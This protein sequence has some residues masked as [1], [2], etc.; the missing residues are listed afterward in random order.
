MDFSYVIMTPFV[1]VLDTFY[2]FVGSYGIALILFTLVVRL[3]L[4]PV[5]LKGKKMIEAMKKAYN[6]KKTVDILVI[7]YSNGLYLG[8]KR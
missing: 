7:G 8:R 1:W 6:Q 5:S 2:S 3:I 4:F